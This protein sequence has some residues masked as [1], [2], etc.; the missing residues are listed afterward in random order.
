MSLLR[1]IPNLL[2]LCNLLC[3]VL[4]IEAAFSGSLITSAYF[5]WIAGVF[6]F[7]DGMAARLLKVSS[8][9]GKELD[10]LADI[11][12]FGVLPGFIAF[13]LM[14]ASTLPD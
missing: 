6:D 11:I 14:K 9:I 13:H 1:H 7:L 3:G 10:S 12:S 8:P 5:L 2:T 4:G